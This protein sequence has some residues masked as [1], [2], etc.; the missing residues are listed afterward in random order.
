MVVF[1][2]ALIKSP[3]NPPQ[4]AVGRQPRQMPVPRC[5]AATAHVVNVQR[6]TVELR[7]K[8]RLAGGFILQQD[9]VL[10]QSFKYAPFK[11]KIAQW[12]IL[13]PG[14]RKQLLK[15]F[16]HRLFSVLTFIRDPLE[17]DDP[18]LPNS[19]APLVRVVRVVPSASVANNAPAFVPAGV[20]VA[21]R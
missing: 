5:R 11:V 10:F 18:P 15:D 16:V 19:N 1:L 12:L 8:I 20:F 9:G 13:I 3:V 17:L 7:H 2:D 14:R 4:L 6:H 21:S